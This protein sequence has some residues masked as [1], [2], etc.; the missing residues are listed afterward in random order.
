MEYLQFWTKLRFY[1]KFGRTAWSFHLIKTSP[2]TQAEENPPDRAHPT[3]IRVPGAVC[4]VNSSSLLWYYWY[5]ASLPSNVPVVLV[6]FQ[7]DKCQHHQT[8][9]LSFTPIGSG[10]PR[11]WIKIKLSLFFSLMCSP[12]IG[13]RPPRQREQLVSLLPLTPV[14]LWASSKLLLFLINVLFVRFIIF[15]FL[16]PFLPN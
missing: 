12:L 4:A 9:W 16:P 5:W 6:I 13:I 10:E 3:L 7:T 2:S 14:V 8:Y 11:D 1:Q 15:P